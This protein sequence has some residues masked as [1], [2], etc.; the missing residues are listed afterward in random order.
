M[1]LFIL[2]NKSFEMAPSACVPWG[3]YDYLTTSRKALKIGVRTFIENSSLSP[4]TLLNLW[5]SRGKKESR[6]FQPRDFVSSVVSG[7][8]ANGQ[9]TRHD[10][11]ACTDQR[12]DLRFAGCR[13]GVGVPVR[14][15][16]LDGG[17]LSG[18][19]KPPGWQFTNCW[20]Q[21]N[22]GHG[23]FRKELVQKRDWRTVFI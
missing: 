1:Y 15:S 21:G 14:H 19:G 20:G 5:T 11:G 3:M 2:P 6:V 9:P 22:L 12:V 16:L 8:T 7:G 18:F 23:T 13:T 17:L 4:S 10:G